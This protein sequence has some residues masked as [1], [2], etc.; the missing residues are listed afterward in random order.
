MRIGIL[1]AGNVG[2]NLG[3]VWAASGHEI[4]FGV[5][6][7]SSDRVRSL[8]AVINEDVHVGSVS[9]AVAFADVVVLA[10]GWPAAEEVIANAGD[11]TGKIIIDATNRFSA[12]ETSAAE[13]VAQLAAGAKVV[14]AFNTIGAE[15]FSNPQFGDAIASM[16]ICGDDEAAKDTVMQLIDEMGFEV[17]DVGAL[18]KAAL[19]ESLAQLWVSMARGEFGR[20]IA[21][22][23]LQR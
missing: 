10:V 22:K 7:P 8:L 18:S 4:A 20:G 23:L 13:D 21:F 5:R 1:G 11:W 6:N 12:S 14:K 9:Q 16:F 2:G 15:L 19:L 17:V 3:Q